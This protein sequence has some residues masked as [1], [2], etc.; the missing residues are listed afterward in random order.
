MRVTPK[1]L[2]D[3][4]TA[5]LLRQR[6]ARLASADETGKPHAVP[7]C[8]SLTQA[9]IYIAIDEKP[10]KAP[11]ATKVIDLVAVLQQSLAQSQGAKKKPAKTAA[12]KA[13]KH[14]ARKAA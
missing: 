5:F 13:T 3:E 11:T 4:Q 8:F 2:T 9:A 1:A 12:K 10:K 7:V 14:A 6:V